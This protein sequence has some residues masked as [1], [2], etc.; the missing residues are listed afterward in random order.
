M[1]R[2]SHDVSR[3]LLFTFCSYAQKN[4]KCIR[5]GDAVAAYVI[6]RPI[7]L[8]LACEH[9]SLRKGKGKRYLFCYLLDREIASN[10]KFPGGRRRRHTCRYKPDS[11]IIFNVKKVVLPEMAIP[12]VD[13]G[14][15]RARINGY[16]KRGRGKFGR[17]ENDFPLDSGKRSFYGETEILDIEFDAGSF[18]DRN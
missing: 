17:I 9:T 1:K 12:K 15:D 10:Y 8:E 18:T 14:I 6:F 3:R 5:Q 4:S 2:L 13:T 11:G 16:I 7:Y